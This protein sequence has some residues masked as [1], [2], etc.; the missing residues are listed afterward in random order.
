MKNINNHKPNTNLRIALYMI[1]P[2]IFIEGFA[3]I[4]MACNHTYIDASSQLTKLIVEIIMVFVIF[5]VID[6]ESRNSKV[7]RMIGNHYAL[8]DAC[9][10]AGIIIV[11]KSVTCGVTG[12]H[13]EF[14]LGS[15]QHSNIVILSVEDVAEE[16]YP[17]YSI[18]F[19]N[20]TYLK[21]G[22]LSAQS[23]FD[24]IVHTN[25]YKWSGF[26]GALCIEAIADD[27][28]MSDTYKLIKHLHIDDYFKEP[29]IDDNF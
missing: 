18:E 12:E 14:I 8:S 10:K 4:N 13:V 24:T 27:I 28:C 26:D 23:V 7:I 29:C 25:G 15:T 19:R 6:D 5:V 22:K 1:I 3:L 21:Y 9:R 16:G 2:I 11:R 17:H 20:V